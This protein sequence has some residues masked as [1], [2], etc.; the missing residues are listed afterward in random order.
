M[1]KH[2]LFAKKKIDASQF[3]NGLLER[4]LTAVGLTAMGV[5]AVVGA[6][7]F[8]TP[9]IIAAKYAGPGA[10]LSYLLAAVVCA[11]AAL[12]YSEFAST[13]PL[14]GS[15]YTY[16]YTVFGELVA[17]IL[18]WALVSEYLFAVASV[19]VSWSAYFQNLM[20]GFG[21]HLPTALSAAWEPG[22]PA[23]VNLIAGIVVLIVGFLLSNGMRESTRIN[24][25]MVGV[26][27]AVI[28]IFL[29]VAIF[30]VK[31]ANFHP[32]LPYGA[33]GVLSGAALAFYAYIGFDAVSTA[34]EEVI[35]PQRDM[36]IGIIA[37][38][39]IASLL[40]AAVATVLVGVVHYTKLNVGDP[41]AFALQLMH[42]NWVAGIISLGAVAGMT[43]VLLV[44]TYGGTRLIFAMSR[45]GLLPAV[46]A[47]INPKTHV[48][49]ANTWIFAVVT[50]VVA[51]LVPLDKIAELVNIG[52]LF[53]FATVSLGVIFLRRIPNYNELPQGFKVPLYPIVPIL[54]CILCVLLMT[55]LQ[56]TTWIVFVIWL[57]IGLV[58]YFSYSYQHS[59]QRM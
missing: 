47:K 36:P 9:G 48:P 58:I 56:I 17:W 32:F 7:I 19:A 27:I 5:G 14:A 30:Y 18:G 55:Q 21:L 57:V 41:V 4:N 11:L 35:N 46:F 2:S 59:Q 49:V 25:I 31:P 15:A 38:L 3:K 34:S 50:S 29:G 26:K 1:S 42:Q 8:I 51:A 28:V 43:T 33:S 13:I 39:L 40:Y 37:S 52:T 53:A 10:M 23:G 24:T 54:S 44:M 6:G 45:D 16:V 22:K 20:A 12:C